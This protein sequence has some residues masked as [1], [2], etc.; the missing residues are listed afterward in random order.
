MSGVLAT[1][2]VE[3]QLRYLHQTLERFEAFHA[4]NARLLVREFCDFFTQ[5][6]VIGIV[7]GALFDR[8]PTSPKDW[9]DRAELEKSL[10]PLPQDPL[11]AFAFRWGCLRLLRRGKIDLNYF[12][13]NH[14]RGSHLNEMLMHWK[15]LVVHPFAA[16]CRV[17][18]AGLLE[19][20]GD[21]EWIGFHQ[22]VVDYLDGPFAARGF[23]PRSWTDADDEEGT[24]PPVPSA[25]APAGAPKD[26]A[27]ALD[28]LEVAV[29]AAGAV[30][31][32]LKDVA[33][34][35][36]EG[37]RHSGRPERVRARLAA[38]S[39][40]HAQLADVCRDVERAFG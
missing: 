6:D 13:T 36:L 39:A 9:H 16:D 25:S 34:L 1:Q 8:I 20:L 38:L 10:P 35:R 3:S 30:G 14:F 29:R 18:V 40:A 22:V 21:D 17:L 19:Q 11:G 15:R 32:G 5:D 4:A 31:D 37:Q 24:P 12:V 33:A 26:L 2:R 27:A 7:A 28:A 23:G